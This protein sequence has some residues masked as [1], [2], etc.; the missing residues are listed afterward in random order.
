MDAESVMILLADRVDPT[1]LPENGR[2]DL[3]AL[4]LRLAAERYATGTPV[5]TVPSGP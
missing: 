4:L 5:W 3:G 2:R 1:R